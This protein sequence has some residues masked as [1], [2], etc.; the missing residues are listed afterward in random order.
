LTPIRILELRSVWGTGGGPEKTILQGAAR[1]DRRRFAI[2]VCYIRDDRDPIFGIDKK[3]DELAIDYV[4]LR[5]RHSFDPSI[6]PA[7]RRLVRERRIDIVHGHEYKTNLLAA[8]LNRFSG[9]QALSTVHGWDGASWR[10]RRVYY[11]A[12]RQILRLLPCV[13][14]VSDPV[15][16]KLLA[17]GLQPAAVRLVLNGIDASAFRRDRTKHAAARASLAIGRDQFVMGTVGRLTEAKRYDVLIDTMA[18]LRRTHPHLE[19]LIAGDGPLREPLQQQIHRLGLQNCCR[20]LGQRSDVSDLHHAFDLFVQSSATE[21]TPNAVLEAMALETPVV[22][23]DVGG[24]RQLIR[25]GIDGC[26]VSTCS[27]GALAAAIDQVVRAPQQRE[28]WIAAARRRVETDLS[29]DSRMGKVESIYTEL[30]SRR[31]PRPSSSDLPMTA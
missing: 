30:M 28:T 11:P 17:S 9:V 2:T 13:I 29:F 14:A 19:L 7:L 8:V 23:T 21:G 26:L 16:E 3:A 10:E 27:A 20:L 6:W 22:A 15:R 18:E 1:T 4:E 12:D 5:E 31:S 24:T 25:H